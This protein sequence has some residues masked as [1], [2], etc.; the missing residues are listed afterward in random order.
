M[1]ESQLDLSKLALDRSD[2]P[3]PGGRRRSS[4]WLTRYVLPLG[5]LLGFVALLGA[6]AGRQLLPRAEVTVVPVIVK[7]GQVQRAGTTLF[8]AAGWIEPRPTSVSVAALAPGVVEELSVV[9]GQQV[10][11]G[12][13]IAKLIQVDAQLELEQA[14]ASLEIREGELQRAE[15][16]LAAARTRLEKPVHLR[17]KLADAQSL[18]AKATTERD[19]LPF[20]QKAAEANVAFTRS[21]LEGKRSAQNAIAGVLVEQAANEYAAAVA[22]LEELQQRAPNLEKEI[23]AL[24]EKVDALT[25]QLELLVEERR[26]MDEAKAKVAAAKGL[27]HEAKLQVRQAELALERTVIRAPMD[28]RILRL[29]ALPGTRVMGMARSGGQG[30]ST[31]VEMYDPQR[32]QVRADVR[33]EDVPMVTPGAPVE[34]ETASIATPLKGRVLQSTSSASI[35]KNTLE[36]KVELIDPP[37]AVSP[38]MLVT[39]TFL[40]PPTETAGDQ[41]QETERLFVPQRLVVQEDGQAALWIVDAENRAQRKTIQL[42]STAADGL[43]E[44]LDGLDVTDK[45][46]ASGTTELTAGETVAI[47]GEDTVIGMEQ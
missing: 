36:V 23:K 24:S 14:T 22:E 45:L 34:I 30:S 9:E 28:G 35:Q 11:R 27:L 39:A 41:E 18:L 19:K 20:L 29:V 3:S 7:R 32:L 1:S 5:I 6:A 17:A 4:R 47:G 26:Q 10:Q 21:S 33:L 13:P 46:I 38:E 31:V 42:G 40:A 2:A 15:A 37:P 8:Q 12:Q 43:V 44:V 16:E 25:T